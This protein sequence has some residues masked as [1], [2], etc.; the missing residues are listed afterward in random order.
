MKNTHILIDQTYKL[1]GV[2]FQ[3][4]T[5]IFDKVICGSITE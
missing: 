4:Y 5:I 1:N 2:F 3:L